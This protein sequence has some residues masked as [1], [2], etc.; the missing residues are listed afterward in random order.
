MIYKAK[1]LN[2]IVRFLNANKN[3]WLNDTQQEG[4]PY[5]ITSYNQILAL[6]DKY[7]VI[8]HRD[9]KGGK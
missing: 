2:G 8:E 6:V 3:D 1:E 4:E 9:I 7:F 5:K